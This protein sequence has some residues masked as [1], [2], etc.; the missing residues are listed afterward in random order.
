[1]AFMQMEP[2]NQTFRALIGNGGKFHIPRFQR[3]YAWS[4]QQWEDLWADIE[5]LAAGDSHYMGY[6][7]LQRKEVNDFEVI[8]GQQRLIT[9][10]LV[11]LAAI[12]NIQKLVDAGTEPAQNAERVKVLTTQFVGAKDPVSL[13]VTSKLSL[14]RNNS[15]NFK[16]ICSSLEAKNRRGLTSTNA[17]LNSAFNFFTEKNMGDSGADIARFIEGVASAMVFTTIVVNDEIDAYKVFETLNARG[18][19]L[20]TPDLLKNY[21]FS[22]VAKNDDVT[23]LE[24][25]DIDERWTSIVEQLG[26]GNFTDFVKYHY[27]FQHPRVA[28]KDMFSA[29]RK[30]V[31]T[32]E[33][34]YAYLLSLSDYSS[35]YAALLNS[36]D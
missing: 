27:S 29:I 1:M 7:V 22:V 6:V 36:N 13:R 11:A 2:A 23:D 21:I 9:L 35:V 16:S 20:S 14:N 19:Q 34:A 28:K 12:K 24:L 8:D 31:V 33:S 30:V 5:T 17:L 10:S 26:E 18:V 4:Q 25:D 32:K 15:T 3:D